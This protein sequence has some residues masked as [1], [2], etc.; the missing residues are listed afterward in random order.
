M[1]VYRLI[2]EG[3]LSLALDVR[4]G[5]P[6]KSGADSAATMRT[7]LCEEMSRLRT[8]VRSRKPNIILYAPKSMLKS[9]FFL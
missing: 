7:L 8:T 4:D 3:N 2:W 6:R 5:R 9:S 1:A